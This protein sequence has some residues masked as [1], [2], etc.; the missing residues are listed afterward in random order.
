MSVMPNIRL[1]IEYDGTKFV[2]W[3]FQKNGRSVQE[4]LE[5]AIH[6]LFQIELRVHGGG[7]TDAG[8]HAR[9]QVATM[10]MEKNIH[11]ERLAKQL[12][13]VLPHDVV[14]KNAALASGDFHARHSAKARR[15][16]YRISSAPIAI[17]RNYCWQVRSNLDLAA[18]RECATEI[19]GEHDFQSFCKTISEAD[20]YRCNVYSAQWI[21][22]ARMLEFEITANRFLHGMVRA[23]VGTMVNVGR[24]HTP[25]QNFQFILDAKDRAQ[26]G[27]SAPAR[28]L[29]L[30]EI[31]Y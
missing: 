21:E 9:G 12:T 10:F 22:A 11:I 27:M 16:R 29:F 3:Q 23:L 25:L 18:M 17:E 19:L 15:Y 24:G 8:V 31:V 13:A 4:E 6:Q 20:H 30:E 5:K 1:D 14:V 7:R 26:A 2:G 28:G